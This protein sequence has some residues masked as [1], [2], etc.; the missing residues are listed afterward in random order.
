MVLLLI[1]GIFVQAGVVKV[2][3]ALTGFAV[4]ITPP[5]PATTSFGC[6]RA[7]YEDAPSELK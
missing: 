1:R 6:S 7:D 4:L 5:T 3:T 2:C